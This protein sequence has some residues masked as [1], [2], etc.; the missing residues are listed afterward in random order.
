MQ[1]KMKEDAVIKRGKVEKKRRRE[2]KR[3]VEKRRRREDPR[4]EQ[5]RKAEGGEIT[6]NQNIMSHAC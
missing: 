1:N 3:K 4:C 2:E 6:S 5:R